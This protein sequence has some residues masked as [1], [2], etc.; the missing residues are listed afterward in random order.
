M[1][2]AVV[3]F[4]RTNTSKRVAEKISSKLSCDLIQITD[5]IDW[6]GILGFFRAGRYSAQNKQVEIEI[7]GNLESVDEY[8]L[9]APL[10]A[11]GLAPAARAFLK[12]IPTE[13]VHLVVTSIGNI[14]KNRTGY[15][16]I[17]GITKFS[18]NEDLII[19]NLV[20][21]LKVF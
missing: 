17:H 21:K 11:G 8:I 18:K 1:K 4:T 19:E 9:V 7:N 14:V 3:Y 2:F 10:W 13:K 6:K 16:S 12:T 15:K 20:N 5:N